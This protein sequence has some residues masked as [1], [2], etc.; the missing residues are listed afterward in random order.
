VTDTVSYQLSASEVRMH[1]FEIA[2]AL[3][4]AYIMETGETADNR[5]A[6]LLSSFSLADSEEACE[7]TRKFITGMFGREEET[8][9]EIINKAKTYVNRHIAEDI[10]VSV[11]AAESYMSASYFSRLFKKVVGIGCNEYIVHKRMKI[12]QDLLMTT[13]LPT[14]EIAL[15]VGYNDKNYFSLAFK[16][17]TGMSPTE[18]REKQNVV[19]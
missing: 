11:L 8:N 15:K 18:Y 17:N 13:P 3:F 19:K 7:Y 4:Y 5:L 6:V 1:C 14:G 12:A 10:S 16:R 9:H 2:S